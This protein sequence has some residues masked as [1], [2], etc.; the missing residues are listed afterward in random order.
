MVLVEDQTSNNWA[1]IKLPK[2]SRRGRRRCGLRVFTTEW[3]LRQHGK[4]LM[5]LH[6]NQHVLQI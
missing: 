3:I 4:E 1:G 6:E 5:A 2:N